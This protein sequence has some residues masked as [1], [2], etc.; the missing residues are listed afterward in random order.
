MRLRLPL[1]RP[2]G[3]V[4]LAALLVAEPR[5]LDPLASRQRRMLLDLIRSL[6]GASVTD[7][8]ER[9]PFQWGS[10]SYHL[11]RLTEAGLIQ[12]VADP[13]DGRRKRIY[14]ILEGAV[15]L[16]DPP[17]RTPELRGLSLLVARAVHERPGCSFQDLVELLPTSP[18]N[19]HYHLKRLHE[20]GLVTSGSVSRYRD[21]HPTPKLTHMLPGEVAAVRNGAP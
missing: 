14:P 21:L 6:P 7:L 15:H 13:Q 3:L 10:M 2:R 4:P 11:R 19:I 20:Q 12:I 18:R 17:P 1:R 8:M 9:V 16:I 5:A